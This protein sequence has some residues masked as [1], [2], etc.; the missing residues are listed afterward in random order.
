MEIMSRSAPAGNKTVVSAAVPLIRN[1][2]L[3]EE[4]KV[5][6]CF[7]GL[8]SQS[9]VL[10]RTLCRVAQAAATEVTVLIEGE[11][12]TGKELIACAVRDQ[13]CRK[14]RPFVKVNCTALAE[15]LIESELFGH[16]KGA[17]TGATE[18]K[19][20]RF[21]LASGGTIFLDE[22]GDL[23]L[24]SQ[25]KL[26]RILQEG[27]LER[28]G[29]SRT[30][31][32]DTRVIA[33]TNHDLLKDVEE[34]RFRQ[35]LYYR[36]NVFPIS[37]PPLRE[38]K[39]DIPLLVRHFL[40]KHGARLGKKID[41]VSQ[42]VIN[43]FESYDWPGNVRELENLIERGLITCCGDEL[44]LGEWFRCISSQRKRVQTEPE[45]DLFAPRPLQ[46]ALTE[47]KR[48]YVCHTIRNAGGVK[49]R[50]AAVLG[51]QPSYLSRLIRELNIIL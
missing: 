6:P 32:V 24:A 17:F 28:V 20:G 37:C 2:H 49:K 48:F 21:E 4:I 15:N 36:L 9:S 43:A 3:Q 34:G 13:S 8:V 1:T 19:I 18:R 47:I 5:E 14:D 38:R 27:E 45:D 51:I 50:A 23:P 30:I 22:I 44:R 29:S 7:K 41:K 11:T 25:A 35:D 46:Q 10:T 42:E 33:A 39:E 12:G 31:R 40:C 26:L 16:E